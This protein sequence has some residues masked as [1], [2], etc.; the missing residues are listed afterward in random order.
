[1]ESAVDP[2]GGA[3]AGTADDVAATDD[4]GDLE[5]GAGS[6]SQVGCQRGQDLRVEPVSIGSHQGLTRKLHQD[7]P[8]RCHRQTFLFETSHENGGS[9]AAVCLGS[10]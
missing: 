7:A 8:E 1:M 4:D 2:A 9:S 3:H 6:L 10:I 5:S